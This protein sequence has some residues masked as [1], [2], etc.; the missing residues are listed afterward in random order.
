MKKRWIV[1]LILI[2][3]IFISADVTFSESINPKGVV[4]PSQDAFSSWTQPKGHAYNQLTYSYY[5]SRNKYTTL[6]TDASGTVVSIEDDTERVKTDKATASIITYHGEYGVTDGLTVFARIPYIYTRY[7]EALR[8]SGDE[9]PEGIGDINIGLRYNLLKNLFDSGVLMSLQGEVKIPEA[10]DYDNPL[11]HFNLGDGQYDATFSLL[12]G[13]SLGKGYALLNTGYK[14]RFENNEFGPSNF[15]PSD[16]INVSFGGGYAVTSWLSIRGLID[17][18]KSVG[19][20]SVSQEL[21]VENFIFGG[22]SRH[23]DNVLIRDTLELEQDILNIGIALSLNIT[24]QLQTIFS[25]NNDVKG[26][27]IFKTKDAR[28]GTTYNITLAY[29]F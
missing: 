10:Y 28:E 19:N 13:K 21:I 4:F 9:G 6:R 16:Q 5:V 22:L 26:V 25:Y 2:V 23:Q 15:K 18:Q 14:F 24:K 8:F 3:G 17:W 20:A 12:F 11:T 1:C 29:K 27:G 7:D